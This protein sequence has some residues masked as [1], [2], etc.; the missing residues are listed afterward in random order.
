VRCVGTDGFSI[1]AAEGGQAVHLAALP[2][3][4]AVVEALHDLGQL[5]PRGA[6]FLFLPIRLVNGTGGPGRALAVLPRP[7]L[8]RPR[9]TRLTTNAWRHI[10]CVARLPSR[11]N[12]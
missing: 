1:G 5:P 2:R 10:L 12:R 3:G 11:L 8:P 6:W 7:A 4:M 9:L